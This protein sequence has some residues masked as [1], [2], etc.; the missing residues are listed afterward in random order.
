ME[1]RVPQQVRSRDRV[2]R[3]LEVSGEIVVEHGVEGITTRAIASAA[4]LPVASLYQYFADKEAVLLALVE[5]DIAEM[6]AQLAA[7]LA[8]LRTISVRSLVETT[9]RAFVKVY[10]QRPS[11]VMIWFRGR[12]NQAV[13]DFVRA[14]NRR[15]ARDLFEIA[16]S[17]GMSREGADGLHAELA[18]EVGDRLFQIAFEDSLLGD[19]RVIEE[20]I[21]LVTAYIETHAT[22]EGIAGIPV[23]VS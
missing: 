3:I 10:H 23:P 2:Q 6:D 13:L 19:P 21:A 18:I 20:G 5:R 7:D 14:H 4:G 9:M 22:P 8:T 11:F 12:A 16:R 15:M 17:I 1:R